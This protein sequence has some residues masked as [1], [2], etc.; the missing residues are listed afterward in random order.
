MS[1]FLIGTYSKLNCPACLPIA[2]LTKREN[3]HH[4]IKIK[5]NLSFTVRQIQ[6]QR[7]I[8]Y[9]TLGESESKVTHSCL[10]LC[11]PMDCSLLSSSV[12]GIFQA[13][14]LEW[15]AISFLRGSSR[16]SNRTRVSRIAGRRDMLFNF[17]GFLHKAIP[18]SKPQN[19]AKVVIGLLAHRQHSIRLSFFLFFQSFFFY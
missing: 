14:L 11:D 3:C 16:P 4:G 5:I 1:Y 6:V 18:S 15:I 2:T 12:H 19:T 9:A 17:S 8:T 7:S 13:R 10:T